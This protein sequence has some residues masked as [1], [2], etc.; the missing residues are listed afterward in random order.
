MNVVCWYVNDT[1]R[2]VKKSNWTFLLYLSFLG[3]GTVDGTAVQDKDFRGKAQK[4]VQFNP[5]QTTATWKVKIFT[6][7][8]FE[9]SEHFQ[10]QLS[11]P[12]MAVLEFPDTATV[13]IVDPGDGKNVVVVSHTYIFC[14][15]VTHPLYFSSKT[16]S[17]VF[18][19]Q[20]E[21]KIEEDV[22]ELLIPVRRSGDASQE[23]MV[24]CYTQQGERN[25]WQ[26]ADSLVVWAVW[27][28]PKRTWK[29]FLT[30]KWDAKQP[31]L[32]T[33]AWFSVFRRSQL[34]Q[35]APYPALCC[36]TPITSPDQRTTPVSCALTRTSTRSFAA[37]LSSMIHC[38]RRRRASMSV[39]Q[40]PWVAR[41]GPNSPLLKSPSWQTAMMVS[42][43]SLESLLCQCSS[44]AKVFR[45]F[46][47][48]PSQIPL[49]VLCVFSS[50]TLQ[51]LVVAIRTSGSL[52]FRLC[53][54]IFVWAKRPN[55]NSRL[56]D[57]IRFCKLCFHIL[58]ESTFACG[59]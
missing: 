27:K 57:S 26:S 34:L 39:S 45:S 6:D 21:F 37:S 20:A 22:G 29:Q 10:I 8:E 52:S 30:C 40:W 3:I 17:T 5:G 32:K 59:I 44:C 9:T 23:L 25:L 51:I 48:R 43:Q 18:I 36:P 7:Q 46:S 42:G 13:E 11:D 33:N 55:T 47:R 49:E 4:Q 2:T 14:F 15:I 58:L 35:R 38:T 16:E 50:A 1:F 31:N 41:W 54:S 12:V 28:K 24:V 56:C 53:N 19:P